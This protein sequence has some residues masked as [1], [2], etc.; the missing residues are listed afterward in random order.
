MIDQTG[1]SGQTF[2]L[3]LEAQC[4]RI[5]VSQPDGLQLSHFQ[6]LG[7]KVIRKIGE[8]AIRVEHAQRNDCAAFE[9]CERGCVGPS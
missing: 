9:R 3:N 8:V 6:M 7:K 4:D 5:W 1:P 2:T